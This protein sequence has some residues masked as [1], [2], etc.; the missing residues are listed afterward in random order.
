MKAKWKNSWRVLLSGIQ[1]HVACWK[2][3]HISDKYVSSILRVEEYAKKGSKE[4][5][6]LLALYYLFVDKEL[7]D[8]FMGIEG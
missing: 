3:V 1:H 6:Q 5:A 2:L 8:C 7:P 4:Q